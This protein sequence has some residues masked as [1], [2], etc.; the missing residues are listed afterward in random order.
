M[1]KFYNE[2]RN[3]G[4]LNL[5]DQ[6]LELDSLILINFYEGRNIKLLAFNKEE[7]TAKI[8]TSFKNDLDGVVKNLPG[9]FPTNYHSNEMIINLF[10]NDIYSSIGELEDQNPYL[11]Y[12]TK[13]MPQLEEN[14]VLFIY[15]KKN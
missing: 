8:V 9:I 5:G 14:P 3:N 2:I 10:P 4:L 1:G 7:K 6:V 13:L 15:R 11:D 12:L